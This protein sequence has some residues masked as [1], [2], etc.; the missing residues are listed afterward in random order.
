MILCSQKY[1]ILG[2]GKRKW[3]KKEPKITKGV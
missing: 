3:V 2:K 1:E